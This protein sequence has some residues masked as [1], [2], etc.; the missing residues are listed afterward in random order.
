MGVIRFGSQVDVLIPFKEGIKI[1]VAP[2]QEIK[3][4]ISIIATY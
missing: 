1:L 4:G 3:A 2:K